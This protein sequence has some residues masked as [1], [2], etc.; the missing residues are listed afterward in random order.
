MAQRLGRQRTAIAAAVVAA[1]FAPLA[2]LVEMR[3]APLADLDRRM[4]EAAYDS[5]AASDAA[6]RF[7]QV[8]ADL[9]DPW[10]VRIALGVSG[11]V[12]IARG[13]RRAGGWLLGAVLLS[14]VAIL[15]AKNL[16]D[17]P[18][19][20]FP[21]PIS[22]VAGF[23][24][25]SGHATAA[26]MA[27]TVLTVVAWAVLVGA[28]RWTVIGVSWALAAL[29]AVDRVLLGVHYP[30]DAVGGLL[31]GSFSALVVTVLACDVAPSPARTAPAA[32]DASVPRRFGVVLN[33]VKVDDASVF[34]VR[35]AAAA[36]DAGWEEPLWYETTVDDAGAAM[37]T[38][39]LSAGV[40]V[41]AVAGGDGTV[42]KVCASMAGSGVP[43]GIIP[44]GTGNLLA[45]NLGLPLTIDGAL[46]VLFGGRDRAVDMVCVE[47]DDLLVDHFVVMAGLG[48]DAAIMAG[49]D[50]AIKAKVGWPA[51]ALSALRHVRY[52][53][54]RV[55]ISVDD[56]PFE[57]FRARTVVV[58]NVGNL[59]AGIP[60]LPQAAIDDGRLDVVVIA[61][62]RTLGWLVLVWR[63]LLRRPHT[64]ERLGRMTGRRVVVRAAQPAPRQLDGDIVGEGRE[65]RAEVEA[66]VLLI[67]VPR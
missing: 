12:L 67:R 46:A 43:V 60:L 45:R 57:R 18:R 21:E 65:L 29:V 55:D 26:G 37:A 56:A 9:F 1:L 4:V 49:A 63:V 33:P 15:A 22:A 3:W 41:V 5:V 24:F 34:K 38:A 52:P 30:T 62:R 8:V 36:H 2:T 31:L 64:D 44:T 47:G 59:Q 10:A 25:P 27:A 51:Y 54:V 40:N 28:W 66:G 35:V 48:L 50:D 20:F 17:R 61:P 7:W 14:L 19:P 42:R 58:G 11:L 32:Q 39:A 23:S 13:A 6:V 16:F 53:A